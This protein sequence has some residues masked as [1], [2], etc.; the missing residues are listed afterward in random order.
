MPPCRHYSVP[1]MGWR[2]TLYGDVRIAFSDEGLLRSLGLTGHRAEGGATFRD[3][4]PIMNDAAKEESAKPDACPNMAFCASNRVREPHAS[5]SP[6]RQRSIRP[7]TL[8]DPNARRGA[9]ISRLSSFADAA[10]AIL[11]RRFPIDGPPRCRS[12]IRFAQ[13][14]GQSAGAFQNIAKRIL[15][16]YGRIP[17]FRKS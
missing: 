6:L 8:V 16:R 7:A 15:P 5:P 11:S 14:N 10:R 9:T 1:D 4:F 2:P 3:L 17:E 13:A 12:V